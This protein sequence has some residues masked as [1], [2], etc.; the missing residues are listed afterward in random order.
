MEQLIRFLP[1]IFRLINMAPQD[2]GGHSYWSA[3]R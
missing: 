2:S 1:I 3:D